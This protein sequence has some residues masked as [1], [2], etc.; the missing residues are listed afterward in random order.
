MP[1]AA[2][3]TSQRLID[4]E[5]DARRCGREVN[6]PA[7]DD[8]L[9]I[10]VHCHLLN[11][12]DAN[13]SAFIVRRFFPD[14]AALDLL[15]G[16]IL[17]TVVNVADFSTDE[18]ETEI[19]L[20]RAFR[21]QK[22][23]R[24]GKKKKE[25]EAVEFC[26]MAN[27][28]VS[29]LVRA[30][31]TA[32]QLRPGDGRLLGLAS[33]RLRNAAMMMSFWPEV[34]I[35]MPLMIDFREGQ[36]RPGTTTPNR[37]AKFYREL[38]LTTQ[39]R[40]LP[41]IS[42]NPRR[43]VEDGAIEGLRSLDLVKRAIEEWGFIGVKLHP[44]SGFNPTE[45]A[46][47]GCP[48]SPLQI[49]QQLSGLQS[50]AID[51][52]MEA[53]YRTCE[54]LDVP[55]LTH[56]S[57]SLSANEACMQGKPIHR[58]PK[59][60]NGRPTGPFNMRYD[61][62]PLNRILYRA[63]ETWTNAPQQWGEAIDRHAMGYKERYNLRV[64]LAH[65]AS[66]FTDHFGAK[67]FHRREIDPETG[68]PEGV[69]PYG[70]R[71]DVLP[72]VEYDREGNLVPSA[73]LRGAMERIKDRHDKGKSA[74]LWLDLSHMVDLCYSEASRLREDV[75][76]KGLLGTVPDD[77]GRYAL[78]FRQH[79]ADNPYLIKRIM[80]G[81]DW[82]MP[83]VSKLGPSYRRLMERVL[84]P[85]GENIREAVMGGNAVEFFGLGCKPDGS[86]G[87]NRQRLEAFYEKHGIDVGE[88]PWIKRVKDRM[89]EKE[90]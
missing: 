76:R 86:K 85:F 8:I 89:K 42:Y 80:Y 32:K 62:D 26:G 58:V 17:R 38:N 70:D 71:P 53:L 37:R 1:L 55:I 74:D 36:D 64:G 15:G 27:S 69:R 13:G 43:Q 82:H 67:P 52:A 68:E 25:F 87:T 30:D 39:G 75:N 81:S 48:N 28:R 7:I 2:C 88:I 31:T 61:A 12:D 46:K 34:D 57:D 50:L 63:P 59:Y 72:P 3:G 22:D 23:V 65:Y 73:W 10:D 24:T 60:E 84:E 78:A 4:A 44:T 35:F 56:G 21:E 90:A 6:D 66:R 5:A 40:F 79:L 83:D 14:N 47:N 33:N 11:H 9:R 49:D 19:R 51:R 45:N 77:D 20:L 29:G 18:I 16:G 41:L 54:A